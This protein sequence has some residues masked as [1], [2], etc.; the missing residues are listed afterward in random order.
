MGKLTIS[1]AIF[2]SKH[3]FFMGKLTISM[4]LWPF[5]IANYVSL[6]EG[7]NHPILVNVSGN[8]PIHL[9][10][11]H[12]NPWIH[13]LRWGK[14]GLPSGQASRS[15]T[16]M[17]FARP[18]AWKPC[19]VFC[20]LHIPSWIM[21]HHINYHVC[22]WY[23]KYDVYDDIW[24]YMMYIMIYDDI[25]CILWYMIYDIYTGIYIYIYKYMRWV[26][27]FRR[28]KWPSNWA[29]PTRTLGSAGP[30][31]QTPGETHPKI[32]GIWWVNKINTY[33]LVI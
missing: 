6:P 20:F 24:W 29:P 4:I 28:A 31:W 30:P 5:S 17:V 13:Q 12:P 19:H 21:Y 25:W 23:M 3:H 2:N 27:F 7:K 33:P 32:A 1:M 26:Y 18:S 10:I 11:H 8:H 15:A 16:S 14:T 9:R 22:I